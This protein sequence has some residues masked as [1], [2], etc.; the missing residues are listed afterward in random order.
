M[1]GQ[2]SPV[3]R[4]FVVRTRRVLGTEQ[5]RLSR[6]AT[7]LIGT[8]PVQTQGGEQR[9]GLNIAL[10]CRLLQ[11]TDAIAATGRHAAALKIATS[12]TE[13]RLGDP[14]LR[15]P[16]QQWKSGAPFAPVG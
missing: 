16:A 10:G 11:P 2:S 15:G 3:Q 13:L 14:G 12:D 4:S 8:Q 1:G 7:R 9:L 6:G 5:N